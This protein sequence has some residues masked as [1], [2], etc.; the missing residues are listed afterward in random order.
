[1][2]KGKNLEKIIAFAKEKKETVSLL[3]NAVLVLYALLLPFS[4]AFGVF[5][6]PVILALLWMLEGDLKNK[7]QKIKEQTIFQDL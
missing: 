1:M 3:L 7:L 6:G 5:T 2:T 4:Y